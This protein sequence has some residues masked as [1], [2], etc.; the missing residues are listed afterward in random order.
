MD[1]TLLQDLL[2]SAGE[3]LEHARGKR[4]LRTTVLPPPPKPMGA[5]EVRKLRSTL[6]C[7]QAV[8]ASSLNVST[9]LVQAWEAKRRR[10]EGPA[11]LLLR[12]IQKQPALAFGYAT[13]PPV[14]ARKV[15][16]RALHPPG[17]KARQAPRKR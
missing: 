7:S 16:E 10:P 2:R 3:A 14:K 11:L 4:E 15:A 8:F 6:N 12:L 1:E 13:K 5:L 9:K 17:R